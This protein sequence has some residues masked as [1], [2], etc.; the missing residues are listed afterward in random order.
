[1]YAG[2]YAQ[3]WIELE[4]E[5]P[6][7][8]RAGFTKGG[9]WGALLLELRGRAAIACGWQ[10]RS[11]A[12]LAIAHECVVGLRRAHASN[13]AAMSLLLEAGLHHAR[14]E[15][16]LARQKY[17]LAADGFEALRQRAHVAAARM[18]QASLSEESAAERLRAGALDWFRDQGI[19]NPEAWL[20]MFAPAA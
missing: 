6:R 11:S 5:W 2:D 17:A 18:R 4:R 16:E 14:G 13:G 20:R 19:A 1:L 15:R 12:Q 3:L 9:M 7:L 8:N 10:S